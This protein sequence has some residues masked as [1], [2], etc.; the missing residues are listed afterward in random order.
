MAHPTP[1]A[2]QNSNK[3]YKKIVGKAIVFAQ[4]FLITSL[5]TFI[6][7]QISN[8]LKNKKTNEG[9]VAGIST[10]VASI[11]EEITISIESK[12]SNLSTDEFDFRIKSI[13]SP[14]QQNEKINILDK[15]LEGLFGKQNT[16][17]QETE[18][19]V[20]FN[21]A[22]LEYWLI[23]HFGDLETNE[24]NKVEP[25]LELDEETNKILECTKGHGAT[26]LPI[27]QIFT[28]LRE[29]NPIPSNM[30]FQLVE[31]N[32]SPQ[33]QLIN[34]TCDKIEN[35]ENTI[36]NVKVQAFEIDGEKKIEEK[37]HE[38]IQQESAK[39]IFNYIFQENTL[40]IEVNDEELLRNKFKMLKA[41]VDVEPQ[42]YDYRIRKNTLYIL[43]EFTPGRFLNIDE[44]Y[45]LFIND[46]KKLDKFTDITLIFDEIEQATEIENLDIKRFPQVISKGVVKAPLDP[47]ERTNSIKRL[48][49]QLDVFEVDAN[50]EFS[51]LNAFGE[52][53]EK[54]D[55]QYNKIEI[56]TDTEIL[57]YFGNVEAVVTVLYR[58]ILEA[59]FPITERG[60]QLQAN[61]MDYYS[62]P[63]SNATVKSTVIFQPIIEETEDNK[64]YEDTP[65]KE[66]EETDFSFVNNSD[67][68][69][70]FITKNKV[71]EDGALYIELVLYTTEDYVPNE[72]TLRDFQKDTYIIEDTESEGIIEKFVRSVNGNEETFITKYY[73]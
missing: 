23:N 66:V 56:E 64:D 62:Y 29:E 63:Y 31:M 27:K 18:Y 70:L 42:N 11:P 24:K 3:R 43:G 73:K 40:Q 69:I 44:S 51:F 53:I 47:L 4:L 52:I 48:L 12:S 9:D 61:L 55:Y 19:L 28:K 30:T 26:K 33:E 2:I 36:S 25:K 72:V 20:E 35:F 16:K 59:G 58:S 7:I 68:P 34:A 5:S 49:E 60:D 21:Q 8:Y 45:D 46:I 38:F 17:N 41:L 1:I 67:S 6:F 54:D 37:G 32:M 10:A 65:Q 57:T 13:A 15:I 39:K 71:G 14:E 22:K 50:S